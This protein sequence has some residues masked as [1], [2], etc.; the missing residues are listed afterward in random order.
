MRSGYSIVWSGR[1]LKD[2]DRISEYLEKNW[3]EKETSTFIK[4]LHKRLNLISYFPKFSS[5]SRLKKNVRKSVLTKQVII[6]YS[7]KNN[8]VEIITLFDSRQHPS[9]LKI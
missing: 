5:K 3:T 9:K 7:F 4:K 1:A 8:V 2:L 6:Y